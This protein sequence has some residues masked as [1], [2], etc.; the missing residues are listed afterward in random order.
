MLLVISPSTFSLIMG[1]VLIVMGPG[2]YFI[3]KKWWTDDLEG[4]YHFRK[5]PK[6]GYRHIGTVFFIAG[7]V[8]IILSFLV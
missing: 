8:M 5:T 3:M 6:T 7:V 4:A 2:L 1:I